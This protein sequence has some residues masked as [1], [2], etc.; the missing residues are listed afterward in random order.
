MGTKHYGNIVTSDRM[1]IR[2]DA[3]NLNID[4]Y[5]LPV[6]VYSDCYLYFDVGSTLSPRKRVKRNTIIELECP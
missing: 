3:K 5:R 2:S 4:S 6:E 1:Q